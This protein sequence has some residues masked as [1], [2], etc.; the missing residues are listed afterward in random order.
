MR[1]WNSPSAT[2]KVRPTISE[3]AWIFS[4]KAAMLIHIQYFFRYCAR[5]YK[6]CAKLQRIRSE[7][8]KESTTVL[9]DVFLLCPYW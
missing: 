3:G 5:G 6:K 7:R 2:S 8:V 1:N 4:D 9:S